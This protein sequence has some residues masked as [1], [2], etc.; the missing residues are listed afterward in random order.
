MES[1]VPDAGSTLPIPVPLHVHVTENLF[2]VLYIV[3]SD[4]SRYSTGIECKRIVRAGTFDVVVRNVVPYE[5]I[6]Q[7]VC[8]T[9]WRRKKDYLST[10]E[11]ED[12]PASCFFSF[13]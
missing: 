4:V 11:F 12:L 7:P 9:L 10:Q 6:F 1:V 2:V 5:D 3:E 8:R 13:S